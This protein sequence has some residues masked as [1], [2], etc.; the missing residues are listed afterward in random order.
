MP[1]GLTFFNTVPKFYN[2]VEVGG[3]KSG[4][5]KGG[6]FRTVGFWLNRVRSW[7]I[8]STKFLPSRSL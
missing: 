7:P 2:A 3:L 4:C 1:F 5:Q 8:K 6:T